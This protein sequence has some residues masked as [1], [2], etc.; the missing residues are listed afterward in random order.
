M[1]AFAKM[2]IFF[3]VTTVAV[4]I[5]A[6]FVAILLF[7]F[8]RTARDISEIVQ[9]IKRESERF[10]SGVSS[11]RHRIKE[12]GAFNVLQT[13]FAFMQSFSQSSKK[14]TARGKKKETK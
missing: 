2:D 5:L 14:E 9:M 13:L 4:V 8:L 12:G 7:Y 11:A 3:L 10:V 6:T 1:E